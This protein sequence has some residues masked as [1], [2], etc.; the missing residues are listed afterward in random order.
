MSRVSIA[1]TNHI[2]ILDMSYFIGLNAPSS[3]NEDVSIPRRVNLVDKNGC[4][5]KAVDVECG[6][7]HSLIVGLNG[8]LHLCGGVGTDGQEDG[9]LDRA[10]EGKSK[11]LLSTDY[12]LDL[13]NKYYDFIF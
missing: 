8:S 10:N 9:Q 6:Y 4:D 3:Q 12:T 2:N 7:V 1:L 11:S 5:L 13:S